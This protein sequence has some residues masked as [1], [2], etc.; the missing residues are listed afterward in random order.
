MWARRVLAAL[1]YYVGT[2]RALLVFGIAALVGGLALNWNWLATIG[3]AP[4]ILSTLPCLVM[5][6]LGLCMHNI[7]SRPAPPPAE[8]GEQLSEVAGCCDGVMHEPAKDKP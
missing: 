7:L 2:R 3:A 1:G 4:I 6:A 8:G 5:C